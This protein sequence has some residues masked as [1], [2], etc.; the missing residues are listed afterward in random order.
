MPF[1]SGLGGDHLWGTKTLT[2]TT[3]RENAREPLR[4]GGAALD[5][6]GVPA[7][8]RRAAPGRGRAGGSGAPGCRGLGSPPT[9]RRRPVSRAPP[10]PGRAPAL[11]AGRRLAGRGRLSEAFSAAAVGGCETSRRGHLHSGVLTRVGVTC[12]LTASASYW[13]PRPAVWRFRDRAAQTRSPPAGACGPLRLHVRG[14]P[15]LRAAGG[16]PAVPRVS[17]ADSPALLGGLRT[18]TAFAPEQGGSAPTAAV[19]RS[20]VGDANEA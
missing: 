18:G 2:A 6:E 16:V 11:P 14:R 12:A 1:V 17:P 10:H 4:A 7:P 5:G 13:A 8:E 19:Y 15:V 20:V 3:A 9:P